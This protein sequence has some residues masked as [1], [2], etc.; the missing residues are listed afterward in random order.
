MNEVLKDKDEKILNPKI[1]RYE[2]RIRRLLWVNS[3]PTQIMDANVTI[4]LSSDDYDELEWAFAVTNTSQNIFSVNCLKG[5]GVIAI[6]LGYGDGALIRRIIDYVSDT[7][8]KTRIA[9]LGTSDSN[10]HCIPLQ[11]VGIKNN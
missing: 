7:Q 8:Y 11:I 3:N 4:N 1:P 2:K 6:S 9:K 5:K 10:V